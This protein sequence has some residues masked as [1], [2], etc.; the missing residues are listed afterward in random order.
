MIFL[1][2]QDRAVF[3]YRAIL[4]EFL[5][6]NHEPLSSLYRQASVVGNSCQYSVR[7]AVTA[8]IERIHRVSIQIEAIFFTGFVFHVAVAILLLR[9]PQTR[10]DKGCIFIQIFFA[11]ANLNNLIC[12]IV[13]L[14]KYQTGTCKSLTEVAFFRS[15]CSCSISADTSTPR[16]VN[17]ASRSSSWELTAE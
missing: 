17:S 7:F 1:R 9:F 11:V 16:F 10:R 12:G 14:T 4:A 5:R 3:E 6:Q 15:A 2:L 13:R 8:Y